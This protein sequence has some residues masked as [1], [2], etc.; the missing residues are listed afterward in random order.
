MDTVTD[1]TQNGKKVPPVM[2]ENDF[3]NGLDW[4]QEEAATPTQTDPD[5]TLQKYAHLR[6]DES[7]DIPAPVPVVRIAGEIISTEGNITAIAGSPK[8]G[9]SAFCYVI[10]AGAISQTMYD[11][12]EDLEVA[13]NTHRKGVVWIDTEQ[14]RYKH[15]LNHKSILKRCE[16]RKSPEYFLGYNIRALKISE[17]KEVTTAIL[18]AAFRKF[19]GLHLVLIDGIADFIADVNDMET[20]NEIVKFFEELAVKYS[21]TILTVIHLNPN[22][23]KERGNLGSQLQRKVESLLHV[24]VVDDVCTLEPKFLRMA[25]KGNIPLIQFMYD[26]EKGYHTYCGVKSKEHQS[27]KDIKRIQEIFRICKEAFIPPTAYGYTD[28]VDK[29]MQCSKKQIAT[30]KSMF[31]EM[32]IHNMIT[33]GEDGNW[34][35][36]AEYT[37][38][39]V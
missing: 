34:R 20:S 17:Y 7:S 18:D 11:G 28:A 25:G 15:Q 2:D 6:I 23:D 27:E 14:S 31:T 35:L 13:V 12:L 39:P 21:T 4:K 8:S 33:Q 16:L 22:S 38:I 24:K 9:K 36:N 19:G 3:I 32:K 26:R 1:H 10:I 29:I 5:T 30:A 37:G